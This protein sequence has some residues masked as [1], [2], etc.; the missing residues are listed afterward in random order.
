M[1]MPQPFQA[2][3]QTALRPPLIVTEGRGSWLFDD[4][5]RRYLDFV[6]GWAVNALGHCH[7]LMVEA[8]TRQ[9]QRLINPSP[10]FYNGPMLQLANA[11]TERSCLDR[12]F[13]CNSGAE[14]NEGAIKLARKWGQL[15]RDGAYQI[16]TM[17]RAFHGR[18]LATMSASDKAG[19]ERLY[20]PKV[21]GF[22][23]V[24][25]DDLAA[26]E[27]AVGDQTVAILLEPVQGEAG[28]W[29]ASDAFLQGVQRL[30]RE[31]GIL[32]VLDEVQTGI[33]RTGR[34]FAYEHSGIEPDIVTLGK[35]L[36]GGV[37][38]AA[39][40]AREGICC[41]E[42]G[43]QGGTFNG[44]PLMTAMGCA[45]VEEVSKPEFLKQVRA[46]SAYLRQGLE[47][48]S[49]EHGHGEV[50]GLGLLLALQLRTQAAH[51]IVAAAFDRGLLL[52]A[53]REH[54]LRF[55]PSLIVSRDE[56][57]QMLSLLHAALSSAGS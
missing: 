52:N 39:L 28:V 22:V 15:H 57:D 14:A 44:N 13:F 11:L 25:F 56:I 48:L 6:Q 1:H 32:L 24:P 46:S 5:G 26:V 50:R 42:P 2:V 53:P 23:K 33:G 55:M 16:V 51:A 49:A 27:A 54:T 31:R 37:P 12:V 19:W 17:Q 10:S 18:T 7:P 29:P 45:V 40:L 43:D 36:G 3:M 21:A 8:L 30:A 35:G 47:R 20:E 9:A 38:L 4:S 41:F 34:L